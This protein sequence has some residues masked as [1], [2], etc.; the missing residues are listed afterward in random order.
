METTDG[1]ILSS[2]LPRVERKAG[3]QSIRP[4]LSNGKMRV[5]DP[6]ESR[7]R[8]SPVRKHARPSA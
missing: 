6:R 1:R 2:R 7:M 5:T 8:I 3:P 4:A